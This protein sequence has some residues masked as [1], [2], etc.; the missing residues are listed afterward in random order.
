MVRYIP[1]YILFFLSSVLNIGISQNSFRDTIL[2][3]DI[4]E[5]VITATRNERHLS[6]VT[7]PTLIVQSKSIKL[8]GNLRL[9][10]VLQEQTGLFLTSGSG[11]TSVG[12]GVFGN[13]IQIQ[14]MAP[15]YTLIMLDGEPMIGRQGGII[16]LSRFTVGNIQKI[17]VIKGPSSALYGSEAMGGVVNILT[18]Q[19][20]K[21]YFN[22]GLRFG[23]YNMLDIF[24][25]SSFDYKRSTVYSFM[26]YNSSSGYDI[27]K[28][29]PE[30]TMD[31][32]HNFAGQLKWTYR[33]T[34]KTRLIWSN[35][36][37]RGIQ[38]SYFAIG[39]SEINVSGDGLTTEINSNPVL[40]HRINEKL[41]TTFRL[42]GSV[43]KY[44]QLLNHIVTNE[45]YYKDDFNHNYYRIEN[46]TDWNW[47]EK[48][49]IIAGGGYNLQTVLTSRYRTEKTQH[50]GY[51]FLQNEYKPNAKWIVIPGIRIDLNSAY[52]N[53][54]TPKISFQYKISSLKSLNFSYGNGFKSPDFRQL[55]LYYINQAAQGYRVYGA[56]EF[57][58]YE[59]E[60]ELASGLITKILAEAYQITTLRPE[61]SH[62]INIGMTAKFEYSPTRLDFNLFYNNVKDLINY[63]PVAITNNNT[64]VFSYK[65]IKKAYTGGL[66][67]NLN[68]SFE[69]YWDFSIGYQLLLTGDQDILKRVLND[70]VYGRNAPLGSTKLMS[71]WDYSGLLGRSMNMLNAKLSFNNPNN[72]FGGSL[73]GIYRSK[74]GVID[75]DGNGF[76]NMKEE[77]AKGYV[78]LNLSVQK[79]FL[80]KY[81][82]QVCVNNILDYKDSVNVP[83]NPGIHIMGMFI[84]N[85]S[86]ESDE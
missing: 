50:L 17:E 27:L 55:Y 83:Q 41:K 33:F 78:F 1:I 30:K 37:Y 86:K 80:K 47:N 66:E 82:L 15:D 48:N 85:I 51:F 2:H 73:R 14:G 34:D 43:Y 28:D 44:K 7:V 35:R 54:F 69:K 24:G 84:W 21:N 23:S 59:M 67:F 40:T 74:W 16:D 18:E 76:A 42:Y 68:R 45:P 4:D 81:T 63:L 72:G 38:E 46:Q 20:R 19:K 29:T 65:N 60:K 62:G 12:G 22:G 61:V 79:T 32:Y 71:V 31:P 10:E 53:K 75:L 25:A 58:V 3:K 11:S 70:E 64:Y 52:S 56:S 6:N 9:N 26:N 13:G 5:T 39:S 49:Q 57:S 8:S 36:I 77:Y